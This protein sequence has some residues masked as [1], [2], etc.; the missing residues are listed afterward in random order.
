M[1][2]AT[3]HFGL[4]PV[5]VSQGIIYSFH[6]GLYIDSACLQCCDSYSDLA[7]Q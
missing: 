1:D 3:L 2:I 4:D 7:S 6:E 5:G